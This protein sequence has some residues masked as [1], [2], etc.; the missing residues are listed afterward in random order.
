MLLSL[1]TQ[2]SLIAFLT[3][4]ET[5]KLIP[6]LNLLWVVGRVTFYLGYPKYRSFG[7]ATTYMP[8]CL[9]A[10][11]AA[12]KMANVQYGLKLNIPNISLPKL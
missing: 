6:L 2:V 1:I 9:A 7:F 11:Y 4:D 3:A 5:L 8:S 12:Y 10:I